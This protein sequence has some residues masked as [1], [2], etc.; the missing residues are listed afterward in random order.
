MMSRSLFY[1]AKLSIDTINSRG[2]NQFFCLVEP[3][4]TSLYC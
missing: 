4:S 3:L 2:L 1:W